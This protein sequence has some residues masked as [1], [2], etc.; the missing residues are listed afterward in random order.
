M[1]VAIDEIFDGSLG[2]IGLMFVELGFSLLW[3]RV[4]AIRSVL[5]SEGPQSDR[6]QSGSV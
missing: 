3:D 4:E 2:I 5:R 1:F 6:A